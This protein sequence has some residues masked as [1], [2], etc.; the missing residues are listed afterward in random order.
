VIKL[1]VF[2]AYLFTLIATFLA[3]GFLPVV[4][5]SAAILRKRRLLLICAFLAGGFMA[6]MAGAWWLLPAPWQMPLWETAYAGFRSDIYGHEVEHAAENI[7]LYLLF[8]A[9]VT[10]L[11]CGGAAAFVSRRRS[12]A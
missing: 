5:V 12:P 2:A 1:L 10:A 7:F 8:V 11:M 9:N 3:I 6:G 4:L